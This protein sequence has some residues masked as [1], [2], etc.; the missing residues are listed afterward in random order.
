MSN[1]IKKREIFVL[2]GAPGAGKGTLAAIVAKKADL[3]HIASGDLFRD[4][5]SKGT[6]LGIQAKSYMEKGQLV[7]DEITIKMILERIIATDCAK[8][9]VLDG[10]P[11]TLE[12]AVSLDKALSTNGESVTKTLL[13]DVSSEEVVK[14]LSGRRICRQCQTPYHIIYVQ[15]KV[16]GKCDKCGGELYQR[17]DDN[18]KTVRDRLS[19]YEKQTKPVIDYYK[20]TNKLGAIAG[21]GQVEAIAEKLLAAMK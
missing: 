9:F 2:L 19:V 10:F 5:L 14:R 4:A 18:E 12:Q 11:R 13:I 16:T 8:G 20:K 21:E 15:P 6:K 3:P 7:P 1:K 17:A